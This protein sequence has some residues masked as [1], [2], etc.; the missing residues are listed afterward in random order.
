MSMLPIFLK[1]DG[2][3][4]LLVGAGNVA[5][6]KVNS[7]LKTGAPG[8][9]P[10]SPGWKTV[11]QLRVVA[12][13]ARREIQQLAREGKL[14]WLQ[15]AFEPSDLDG[16]TLV[17]AATDVPEVNATV[18]RESVRRGIL[19]NSVD[20]IPNC[21]FFFG[22]VVS[23]G[24]LQ[25]AISTAGESPAVAQRLRREIDEQLPGDLGPWLENLGT[26]RREILAI[27]PRSE[28]RRLLLHQLAH[29]ALCESA[30]CPSRQLAQFGKPTS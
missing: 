19:A 20:D 29:R 23:R 13:S 25:I 11:L 6:D 12:P 4:C 2:R 18:Y 22:S 27:H 24:N 17:I 16:N 26:L 1:L 30:T 15:R 28:A 3:R 7:L 9:R 14:E 5:L 10:S 8:D 21:D